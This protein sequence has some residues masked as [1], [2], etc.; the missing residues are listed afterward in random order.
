[1]TWNKASK[2]CKFFNN[3]VAKQF[4]STTYI[5]DIFVRTSN[6]YYKQNKTHQVKRLKNKNAL[7]ENIMKAWSKTKTNMAYIKNETGPQNEFHLPEIFSLELAQS[8]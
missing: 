2:R 6:S 3:M 5:R 1:M 8:K 7:D 4:L